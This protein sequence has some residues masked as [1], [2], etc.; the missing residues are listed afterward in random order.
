MS[1][2]ESAPQSPAETTA[3]ANPVPP[4]KP[5]ASAP[6]KPAA[7]AGPAD[8]VIGEFFFPPPGVIGKELKGFLEERL[9]TGEPFTITSKKA[10]FTGRLFRMALK[11]GWIALEHIDGRRKAFIIIRGGTIKTSTGEEISLPTIPAK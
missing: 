3:Q 5:A 10:S 1:D 4:A 2:K 7:P 6:A 9:E 11:E 8:A